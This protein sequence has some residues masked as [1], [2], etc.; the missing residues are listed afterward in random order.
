MTSE[1]EQ[2]KALLKQRAVKTGQF[3]LSSGGTSD[4]YVDCK[5]ATCHPQ[6]SYLIARLIL[7][8]IAGLDVRYIGGMTIGSDPIAA[9]VSLLSRDLK[10]P[11]PAFIVRKQQK[12]HGMKKEI[13]GIIEPNS[14]VVIVDDVITKGTATLG[15]IAAVEKIGCK[16]IKVICVVDRQEGGD[17]AL[18]EY[19]Y[20]PIFKKEELI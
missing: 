19:D 2:L 5:Q 12:E 3:K 7:G 13:E 6:G 20:D 1:K 4:F 16:V 8:K 15:A 17:E 14:N 11:I 9:A 10:K 18:E